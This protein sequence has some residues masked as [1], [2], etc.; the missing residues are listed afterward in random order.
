LR[1]SIESRRNES[2]SNTPRNS[3]V[4]RLLRLGRRRT[5]PSVS[6]AE[7]PCVGCGEE[8]AVGSFFFSDRRDIIRSDGARVFLCSD[9][10]ARAHRA[11]HG[12][13]LTDTDLRTI[14]DNGTM[15]GVGLFG[16][17]GIAGF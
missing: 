13:A 17:G 15:I 1:T 4:A 10:Q 3:V 9:C 7:E 12:E 8:T 2:L 11:R 16:G 14:A 5:E 6:N